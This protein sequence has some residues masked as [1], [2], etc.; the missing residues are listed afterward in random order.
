MNTRERFHAVMQFQP[1]DR[2]PMVEWATWWDKTIDRWHTEGLPAE[3][4]DRYALYDY[5]GL[6]QYK[7]MWI[8]PW[9]PAAPSH[10]APVVSTKEEYLAIRESI[11]PAKPFDSEMLAQWASE[12]QR[13]DTVIWFT[14]YGYFWHP[15]CLMGIENHLYA[16]Y[17][18][19]E[20]MHLMNEDLTRFN[21]Q[22]IDQV[23]DVCTPDF[24]TFAED[25]SYNHG[26]MLSEPLFEEFI[27][28]YYRKIIPVLKER[29]IMP[30]VDSDG[31]VG[32]LADWLDAVGVEGILPLERQAGVDIAALRAAQPCMRFLGHFDK[33]TMNRGEAAMRAEFERLLPTLR[34]GGF[35]PSVDHQT[36]PGI[37]LDE[38][39]VYLRLLREYAVRAAG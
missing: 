33:M 34:K 30:I 37:S 8:G 31:D 11:F 25:M 38:Y 24:M 23:T 3:L 27:A 26:P 16:F 20:L 6:D 1:F 22:I 13:G 2:L 21:L 29:N 35:I 10:G 12:Q 14:L 19:P 39:R 5:F 7:Q 28:P 18:Q 17:D 4:T 15:R 36:P 9:I 32:P